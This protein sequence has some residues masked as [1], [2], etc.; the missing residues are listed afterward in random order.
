MGAEFDKE[1]I[2]VQKGQNVI[3]ALNKAL[4]KKGLADRTDSDYGLFILHDVT[5]IFIERD[6]VVC[7]V[8]YEYGG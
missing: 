3:D 2:N 7:M 1:T 6:N 5:V 4:E 8:E